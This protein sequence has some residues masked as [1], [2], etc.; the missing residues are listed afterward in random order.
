MR[1]H[2]PN[3]LRVFEH[4]VRSKRIAR[5][6]L[7]EQGEEVCLAR[8]RGGELRDEVSVLR[9]VEGTAGRRSRKLCGG[10]G[11]EAVE[12]PDEGLRGLE[13]RF[14]QDGEVGGWVREEVVCVLMLEGVELLGIYFDDTFCELEGELRQ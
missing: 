10:R 8:L 11:A 6:V 13:E 1:R 4:E 12:V 9:E 7:L 2:A 3:Q 5:R 14:A